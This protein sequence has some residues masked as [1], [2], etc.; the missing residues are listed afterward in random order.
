MN[1]NNKKRI[2]LVVVAVAIALISFFGVSRVATSTEFHKSSIET[3]EEKQ[4][5]VLGLTASSAAAS[6][7]ANMIPM[8]AGDSIGNALA[9]LSTHFLIILCAI[10]LEKILLTLTGY[11]TFNFLIPIACLLYIIYLFSNMDAL[12]SLGRKL[13]LVGLVLF[14]VTPVSIKISNLIEDTYKASIET[15]IAETNQLS[16]EAESLPKEENSGGEEKSTWEKF[17]DQVSNW[18]TTLSQKASEIS[19]KVGDKVNEFM[20]HLAV[21]IITSCII[22][23]LVLAFLIWFVKVVFSINLPS[24]QSLFQSAKNTR[25]SLFKHKSRDREPEDFL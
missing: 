14:L 4:R 6:A 17:K 16:E 25:K 9:D 15:T 7:V 24:Y 22:P 1:E 13:V 20:N 12:K 21:M 5:T 11:A 2:I 3:L 19:E 23:L 10:F 8:G 18:G